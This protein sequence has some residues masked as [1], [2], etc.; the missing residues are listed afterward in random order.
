[1]TEKAFMQIR[2]YGE[3]DEQAV[4]DLWKEVF[5]YHEPRNAPVTVIRQKLA[6]GCDLFFVA[7]TNGDVVGF[8]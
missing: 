2:S 3:C 5:P 4:I 1:L 6:S 7:Q 8:G